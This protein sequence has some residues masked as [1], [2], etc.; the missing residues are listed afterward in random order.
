M[1]R[2]SRRSQVHVHLLLALSL[3]ACVPVRPPDAATLPPAPGMTPVA[4]A[5]EPFCP[6]TEPDWL[7]PPDDPAIDNAPVPGYYL[8]NQ[9][10]S[11]WASAWWVND[12]E[13]PLRAGEEGN[14]VGWFRPAGVTL[15][16]AGRRLDG[17]AAPLEA[18]VPCC[19][20]TQFQSSALYFPAAGCWAI[21]A[22]AGDTRLDFVVRVEP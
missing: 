1:H 20:P 13:H 4:Q 6:I 11:L 18:H 15:T 5:T 8:V 19:Y 7:T 3:T 22:Q 21:T 14:K 9:D 16:I 10:R 12:A 2:T 17:D